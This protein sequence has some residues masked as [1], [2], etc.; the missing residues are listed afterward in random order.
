VRETSVAGPRTL[1]APWAAALGLDPAVLAGAEV[2][3]DRAGRYVLRLRRAGE[4]CVLKWSHGSA[5]RHE[6]R[7]YGLLQDLGVP[8]LRVLARAE[9]AL[10]LEDL[11]ASPTWRPATPE[12]VK[13]GATG[14]AIAAWYR[15]FH[16]AGGQWLAAQG[17]APSWLGRESDALT[18]ERILEMGQRL[19]LEALPLWGLAAEHVEA[20]QAA[21][22]ALPETLVYTD[23]HWT[24]LALS[25][26]S[27]LRAVV[28]DYHQLGIGPRYAD[29]RNVTWSLG[30]AAAGAFWDAYGPPDARE[31]RLDDVLAPL[32]TLWAALKPASLPAWAEGARRS[33]ADGSLERALRAA[34][35]GGGGCPQRTPAGGGHE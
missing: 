19:G 11:G 3:Q 13:Q 7:A 15:T 23:F 20:L 9:S 14:R 5:A 12:D 25:R 32:Y 24:N 28:F 18:P 29:C 35:E 8:T 33:A 31:A 6:S 22:R 16:A 27:P 30:P 2:L 4:P 26:A 34:L 10:L 21:A 17:G 1:P